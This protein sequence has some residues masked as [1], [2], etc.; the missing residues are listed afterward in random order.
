[1]MGN[2]NVGKSLLFSRMTGIGVISSNYPGTSVEFTEGAVSVEGNDLMLYDLPGTYALSGASE[3]EEIAI[4]LLVEKRPE[5]VIVVANATAPQ[6]SLVLAIQLIELGFHVV[7]ALNF[8]DRARRKFDIDIEGLSKALRLPVVPVVARTGEGVDRLLRAVVAPLSGSTL[9]VRYDSD[10]ERA[11]ATITEEM[12]NLDLDFQARGLGVRLLEGQNTFTTRL[13][14]ELKG[15]AGSLREELDREHG[16]ITARDAVARQRIA[17]GLFLSYFHPLDAK[18]T[19][20]ERLSTLTLRPVSGALILLVVLAG[21]FLTIVMIG[22]LLEGVV[23][24]AYN[25]AFGPLFSSMASLIGGQL[26]QAIAEGISLSILAILVIIIPYVIPFYIILGILEDS[27]YM[28][29]VVVLLDGMMHRLG[30]SGRAIIPMIVGLGCTIPAMLATRIME[31]KKER[32]L[33]ATIT[34][35]AVPCSAQTAIIIGTVGLYSGIWYALLIYLFLFALLIL[36]GKL[37]TKA[38]KAEPSPLVIEVPDL[39]VPNPRNVLYK[40][41][42]RGKDFIVIAFPILLVGSLV[43]EVLMKFGVLDALVAPL[44]PITVGLLGLPAVMIIALVF[45]ILRK[46]MTFQM[47]FVLFGTTKLALVLTP[48]QFFVY[49]MIMAT[50]VPCLGVLTAMRKEFGP[51]DTAKIFILTLVTSF[52]LGALIHLLLS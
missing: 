31:S 29:R 23:V 7:L 14:P 42:A 40:T 49:A 39:A 13:P 43:L 35:M 18:P 27:G 30:I 28:P 46:E 50:Y 52:A 20:G 4:R 5:R 22:G 32:L 12:G 51:R 26:G 33:L 3:D 19:F 1:M 38:M 37:L 47:L 11:L 15:E 10:I 6:Q 36:I 44:S 17:E 41:Y 45:G 8:M 48:H 34:V 9:T 25:S 16:E 2:P 21:L 24:S